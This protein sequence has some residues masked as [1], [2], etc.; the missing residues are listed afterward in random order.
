M[1]N[2]KYNILAKEILQ[3]NPKYFKEKGREEK[4]PSS[5]VKDDREEIC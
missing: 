5:E 3:K 2:E 1:K 4:V